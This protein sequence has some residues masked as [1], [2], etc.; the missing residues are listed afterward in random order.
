[1]KNVF[2]TENM[3]SET[4]EEYLQY[5]E[6]LDKIKYASI[7]QEYAPTTGKRH[8]HALVVYENDQGDLYVLKRYYRTAH[9]EEVR[10]VEAVD[11][12]VKKKKDYITKGTLK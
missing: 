6:A 11:A 3:P 7:C 4:K 2:I 1:M 8:F 10:S 5:V 12:Y 9:I